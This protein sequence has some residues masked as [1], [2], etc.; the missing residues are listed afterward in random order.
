MSHFAKI[1][2]MWAWIYFI[3]IVVLDFMEQ[4]EIQFQGKKT[5]ESSVG[6]IDKGKVK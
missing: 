3:V 4:F 1:Q 2:Q 6:V 5:K